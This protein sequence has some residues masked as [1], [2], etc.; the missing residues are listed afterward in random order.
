[1]TLHPE[2]LAKSNWE[3]EEE[4]EEGAF[5]SHLSPGIWHEPQRSPTRE[6]ELFLAPHHESLRLPANINRSDEEVAERFRH[7]AQ[8]WRTITKFESNLDRIV[9][10]RSYQQIIGLGPQAVPLILADLQRARSHWF[11][12]LSVIVG[13]DKAAGQTSIAGAAEAWLSWGR[14]N[15][16]LN[17]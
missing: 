14:E 5:F 16:L 3:E 2:Y 13:E 6:W 11:W 10:N 15:G 4:E 17:D 8:E 9:L 7:L 12:A 1:M